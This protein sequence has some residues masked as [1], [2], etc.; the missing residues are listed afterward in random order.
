VE[1]PEAAL[2]A[3]IAEAREQILVQA[4]LFTSKPWRVPWLPPTGAVCVWRCCSM[5]RA[6]AG[7]GS[8]CSRISWLPACRCGGDPH[9]IAHNKVMLF[10]PASSR[11]AVATGSYNFTR[12]ARVANAEN[13]LILRGNPALVRAYL[14]NW[15]RHKAEAQ[16]LQSLDNLPARRRKDD[17]REPDR[18]TAD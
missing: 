6:I 1:R 9:N 2:L 8:A 14:D 17:G 10:D 5:P 4:Y 15:L 3:A 12:S 13:L 16:L 7:V 18:A 11:A